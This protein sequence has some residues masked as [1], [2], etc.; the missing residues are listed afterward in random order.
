MIF[1]ALDCIVVGE[2][3][4]IKEKHPFLAIVILGRRPMVAHY[5]FSKCC[6]GHS[7]CVSHIQHIL[8]HLGC[9]SIIK[10]KLSLSQAPTQFL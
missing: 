6:Y 5:V 2:Y 3:I 1:R 7:A 9:Q 10:A 8:V 4:S